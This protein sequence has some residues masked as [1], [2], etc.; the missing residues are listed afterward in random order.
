MSKE[1]KALEEISKLCGEKKVKGKGEKEPDK[2]KPLISISELHVK[3][4]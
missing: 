2:D 4:G 3:N 1:L